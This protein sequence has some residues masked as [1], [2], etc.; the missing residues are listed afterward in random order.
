MDSPDSCEWA[1]R[2]W[3]SRSSHRCN[4]S[5]CHS[6]LDGLADWSHSFVWSTC[7]PADTTGTQRAAG[8]GSD[9]EVNHIVRSVSAKG[10]TTIGCC[11][12]CTDTSASIPV[13]HAHILALA[14]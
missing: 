12:L 5:P 2:T 3:G 4:C 11:P 9:G 1:S 13:L 6:R 10:A 8:A 14:L 7:L